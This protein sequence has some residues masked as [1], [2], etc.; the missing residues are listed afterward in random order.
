MADTKHGT[1]DL[2][3]GKT[4]LAYADRLNVA[5]GG[6]L[7]FQVSSGAPYRASIVRLTGGRM[8][9]ARDTAR[10]PSPGVKPSPATIPA[11]N[12]RRTSARMRASTRRCFS[13]TAA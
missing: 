11:A 13:P 5:Q 9:K 3:R 6:A 2:L 8:P 10:N 12:R 4:I 1:D 7:A